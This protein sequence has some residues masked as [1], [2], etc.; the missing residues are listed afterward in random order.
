MIEIPLSD[1]NGSKNKGK[2]VAIIDEE[3]AILAESY[4]WS[5]FH[6]SNAPYAINRTIKRMLHQAILERMLDGRR[7]EKGEEV[8]HING[9]TLDNRRDNL[10]LATRSQN[11]ANRGVSSKSSTKLKGAYYHKKSGNYQSYIMKDGIYYRL[12]Q[13]STPEEAHEAYCKKAIELFGEF[14]NFGRKK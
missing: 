2:Y 10:R 8:D 3:D 4:S 6:S 1:R 5:V 13:F 9:N 7:L 14:A 12:G 11:A